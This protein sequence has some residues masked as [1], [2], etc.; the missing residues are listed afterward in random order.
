[1]DLKK[2]AVLIDKIKSIA[3]PETTEKIPI[4]CIN[5][6]FEGN[7]DLGSIGCNLY[8]HP[9]TEGFYRIFK[10][11]QSKESVSEVLIG[12]YEVEESDET[13]WPFCEQVFIITKEPKSVIEKYVEAL[14]VD[15]ID[16]IDQSI[17][18]P[19]PNVPDG[20]QVWQLW[21]D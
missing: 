7:D 19:E 14:E 20:Y 4:V 6:F 11:I 18:I 21:W 10:E 13:M 1:M 9:G 5:D 2:R 12:I 17:L 16:I 15:E 3:L 8:E